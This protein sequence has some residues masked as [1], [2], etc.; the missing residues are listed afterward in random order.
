MSIENDLQLVANTDTHCLNQQHVKGRSILQKAKNIYFSD[1]EGWDLTFKSYD[2][3][4][5][6]YKKQNS[7]PMGVVMNAIENTNKIAD[8]VETFELNRDYKYPKLYENSE[9]V[10]KQKVNDGI[11]RTGIYEYDNYQ[12]EYIPRIYKELETY[13]HNGAIDF[14]LLDEDIKTWARE[15][16]MYCGY[17]RGSCSGSIICYLMGITEVDSIKF[18]LNFERFMNTERI[19]L[20]DIDTDWSPIDRDKVKEYIYSKKGLY[21]A[22]IITFNTIALKGSIRDVGRALNYSL[23][24]VDEI[25]K[26]IEDREDYY[27]EKY[28]ELFEYVDII[29]GTIVSV[30]TH[31]CGVCCSPIPLNENMGLLSLGTCENPVTMLNMKEIDSLNYVKL[32]VLGLDNIQLINETCKLVGIERLT[33]QNVDDTDLNVWTSIR[34]DTTGIF[35]WEG[36]GEHYIK[37][38]FSDKTIENI[39]QKVPNFKYI[40]L[41]AV[42]NGAIRPAGSSYRNE[43]ALGIFKD[44]GNEELNKMLSPTLGYLVYQE[45]ILSFLHEFCGYTMGEADMVRRGFA[46]KT[47]TEQ[48]IPRIKEG[49]IKTMKE[50]YNVSKEESE[51]IVKDFIN[52][53]I[54]ASDYLFSLNHSLPYSYIGYICGYLRYYYPLEYITT[55]LNINVSN[56]NKTAK[57]IG[58]AKSKGIELKQPK[59][60]YSKADYYF[61]KE[62]NSIYKGVASIK[63]LNETVANELYGLKDN[64]YNSFLDLLIDLQ[65]TS[66]NSRQLEI[67]IKLG[68][69]S[70][71]G[72]R[73]YLLNIVEM[74]NKY[75]KKKTF[76]KTELPLSIELMRTV[77]EKET[78]KQFSKPNNKKL[79]ELLINCLDDEDMKIKDIIMAELEFCGTPSYKTDELGCR[80]VI[81]LDLSTKYTPVVDFYNLSTGGIAK[82][83]ISKRV[84]KSNVIEKGDIVELGDLRYKPKKKMINGEWQE[85]DENELWCDNYKIIKNKLQH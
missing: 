79:C 31:P 40:D 19:S 68:Y 22:D 77:C 64:K 75:G 32:D 6:C 30:G 49:F 59:F 39:K 9:E 16:D 69:F 44:N 48:H 29:N 14:L 51:I 82:I 42:G 1:E 62:T 7:L 73:Q 2:E 61:N 70:E 53:I 55:M 18:N 46:K 23:D 5:E 54:D 17:S 8:M 41:M 33:P 65:N 15:N 84:F 58:Y 12:S 10:L 35:Q 80:A 57:T 45:Q 38:L 74:Y 66:I 20:A 3:L 4:I 28:K 34:E 67:L 76:K 71:F 47:G 11:M 13:K 72:G 52:V 43:L 26:N 63:Y 56:E 24:L 83:K 50:K 78:D 25:C 85:T 21:C 81:A 27:R 36:T 37:D 60:R